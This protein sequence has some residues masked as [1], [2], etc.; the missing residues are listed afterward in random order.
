[1]NKF[2]STD[3]RTVACCTVVPP[4]RMLL[5]P[6]RGPIPK[7]LWIL[8]RRRSA[9]ISNTRVPFCAN[10]VAVLMLV[11]VLPSCGKALVMRIVLGG[12]PSEVKSKDVRKARYDSDICDCGR[13]IVISSTA[14][15][16][17]ATESPVGLVS[18]EFRDPRG[19]I[20]SDGRL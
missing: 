16:D 4:V 14:S 15:L 11:V 9:S 1:M 13:A 17:A 10:T 12:A 5:N 2:G 20:P 3:E 18:F 7:V 19:I 8:G 6:I